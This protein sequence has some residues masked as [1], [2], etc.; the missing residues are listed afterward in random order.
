MA[1]TLSIATV[2]KTAYLRAGSLNISERLRQRSTCDFVL[3]YARGDAMPTYGQQVTFYDG[4]SLEFAGV[5]LNV[6]RRIDKT[7]DDTKDAIISVTCGDY[8]SVLDWREVQTSRAYVD[9]T[10]SAIV[11][12]LMSE[13]SADNLTY[14]AYGTSDPVIPRV[15]FK[16]GQRYSDA[17]NVI[18]EQAGGWTYNVD[19]SKALTVAPAT[20]FGSSVSEIQNTASDD[21]LYGTLEVEEDTTEY[22]NRVHVLV[23]QFLTDQQT[24]SF[25]GAHG[26]QPTDSSRTTWTMTYPLVST[27]TISVDGVEETVGIKDVDSGKDWYWSSGS[28]EITQDSGGTPLTNLQELTVVYF[29]QDRRYITKSNAGEITARATLE[30]SSGIHERYF[31]ANA[32]LNAV[33]AD[34]YATKILAY[35]DE[36]SY[37]LKGESDTVVPEAGDYV[38]VNANATGFPSGTYTIRSVQKFDMEGQWLRRRVEAVKGPL[39]A[40]GLE[41]FAAVAG[42]L[43]VA[44]GTIS[45]SGGG[46]TDETV[47][48]NGALVTY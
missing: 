10:V 13:I 29:G 35:Y 9:Q 23:G 3:T 11:T 31:E 15:E 25:D 2:D 30:G 21:W 48:I 6:S 28:S 7:A 1:F 22:A 27:P 46:E 40:D 36:P 41:W 33:D 5:I 43:G 26:T 4:A 18:C 12:D 24:E 37:I 8:T 42:N 14:S 38:V 34:A 20:D 39:I 32:P 17:L 44:S 16:Q 45:A 19:Y 47:S